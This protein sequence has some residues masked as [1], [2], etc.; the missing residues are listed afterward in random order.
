MREPERQ[1]YE[2]GTV[3]YKQSR[4]ERE[5]LLLFMLLNNV[6]IRISYASQHTLTD[7]FQSI[8]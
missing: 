4:G 8:Q 3:L 5:G 1:I 6:T 2:P 7:L